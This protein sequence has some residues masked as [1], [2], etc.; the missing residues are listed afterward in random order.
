M[1]RYGMALSLILWNNQ[2]V[3]ANCSLT[4]KALS[5]Y[6]GGHAE[7]NTERRQRA[8]LRAVENIGMN[9]AQCCRD[10]LEGAERKW[11]TPR[12][13]RLATDGWEN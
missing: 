7:R 4:D 10:V 12:E 5:R 2:D 13:N 11:V 9:W 6:R 8:E 3:M 1:H